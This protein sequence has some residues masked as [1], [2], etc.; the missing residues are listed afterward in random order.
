M[1]DAADSKSAARKGVRVRIPPP[2]PPPFSRAT[3]NLRHCG[4]GVPPAR[5]RS[6]PVSRRLTPS[7]RAADSVL[8]TESPMT[9][10]R[11]AVFLTT[12]ADDR[13]AVT[14][15][16]GELMTSGRMRV[17]NRKKV[18][19]M[20][21]WAL[22]IAPLA[23]IAGAQANA[24][25][26]VA[27]P[28]PGRLE[29]MQGTAIKLGGAPPPEGP[30]PESYHWEIVQGEGGALYN[31]DQYEV[32]FQT[33]R[34][35]SEIELFVVQMTVTYEGQAPAHSTVHIR[36][37][38]DMPGQPA[39]TKNEKSIEDVMTDYYHKES[40]A[41]EANR[42]RVKANQSRV[43]SHTT[44]RGFHGGFGYG[45]PGWGWG[46]GWGWPATYPIYAPIVVP[47]P[48]IDW[49]PGDGN[50]GEPIAVPYD[51]LVTTFPEHIA[52]DYLPQDYPGAETPDMG[53][54]GSTPT[55]FID[56]PSGAAR[57]LDGVDMEPGLYID[58][59]MDFAE[60]MI[61]PGFGFDDFDW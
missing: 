53:S 25:E 45:G 47:P 35:S 15:N 48:G 56:F 21:I 37:H 11:D 7:V 30:Q 3:E 29:V 14:S 5:S 6:A 24:P 55:D 9:V 4:A 22:V 20:C 33:P 39:E 49:G 50:W 12:P 26:I 42:Q 43:V 59:G 10:S 36:V 57:G 13:R 16:I 1:V 28:V 32:I 2:A 60:P 51:D 44:Y 40:D 58:D 18:W 61:D 54:A 52:D 27:E 19:T 38:R 17:A 23:P 46:Y 31:E 34:I 41:R 8:D